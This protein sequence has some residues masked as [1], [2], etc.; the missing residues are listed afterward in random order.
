MNQRS[1]MKQLIEEKKHLHDHDADDQHKHPSHKMGKTHS[2]FK[3]KK[4]GGPLS[5][6]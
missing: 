1:K 2:A 3:N 5:K 6:V 4:H